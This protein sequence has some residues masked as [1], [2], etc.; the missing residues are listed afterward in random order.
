MAST[1]NNPQGDRLAVDLEISE[2]LIDRQARNVTPRTLHWYRYNLSVWREYLA[3]QDVA[4]THDVTPALIRRF[5]VH[6]ADKNHSPGGVFNLFSSLR[7]FINWY[8]AEYAPADWENPLTRIK[9]PKRPTDLIEPLGLANLQAMLKEC[10]AKTY[11]GSRDAAI[12]LFL[13]DTGVRKQEFIDLNIGDV[14]LDAGQVRVRMGKGQKSRYVFMGNKTRRAVT[15][16]LRRRK[17]KDLSTRADAPLWVVSTGKRLTPP[18]LREVIRR[19]A[20]R[21]GV[22]EPGLHDF[23]RAFAVNALRAGMDIVT[24][25]R[26]M[27]HSTLATTQRYL[28]LVK[29]D[30]RQSHAKAS[31]VDNLLE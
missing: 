9:P 27:G 3:G 8:A 30:L 16:Y 17:D 14:D 10:D 5:L 13:L 25:A 23:R 18:G 2:F 15:V 22:T 6:L 21:A 19:L 4:S 24:L 7:A 31:P 29:D 11:N 1:A 26:L 28:A 12:L 20:V